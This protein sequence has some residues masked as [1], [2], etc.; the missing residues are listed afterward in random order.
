M[1][2]QLS[3]QGSSMTERRKTVSCSMTL[4]WTNEESKDLFD[5]ESNKEGRIIAIDAIGCQKEIAQKITDKKADDV[6]ALKDNHKK[7]KDNVLL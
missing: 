3:K 7:L 2:K 1:K 6:L 5:G 4:Q